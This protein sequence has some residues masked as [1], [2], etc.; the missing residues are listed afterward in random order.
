MIASPEVLQLDEPF[1]SLDL[2]SQALLRQ[3]IAHAPQQILISTHV[4]DHVR[5]FERVIWL[6]HGKVR[7]D[8]P[9]GE[10]CAAYEADVACR[11]ATRQLAFDNF[12]DVPAP[13]Q[14]VARTSRLV[15]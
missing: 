3:E 7:G 4:L 2:P 6:D 12:D 8:G 5:D 13:P 15:P 10:V 11:A 1:A 14:S 9:G